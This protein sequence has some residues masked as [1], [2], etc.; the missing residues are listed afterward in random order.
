MANYTAPMGAPQIYNTD[1]MKVGEQYGTN[2]GKIAS[3][4]S[5]GFQEDKVNDYIAAYNNPNDTSIFSGI[6]GSLRTEKLARLLQPLNADLA[7]QYRVK[8][9]KEKEQ[10]KVAETNRGIA[11]AYRDVATTE[12]KPVEGTTRIDDEISKIES[13]LRRRSMEGN[14]ISVPPIGE[15]PKTIPNQYM[16]YQLPQV[17]Q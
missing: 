2:I 6:T 13:E 16:R 11:E 8:A 3:A 17:T 9:Q 5:S 4:V 7:N 10:E 12:E 15:Y 14:Q 1:L